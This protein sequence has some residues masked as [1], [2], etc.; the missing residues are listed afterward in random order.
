MFC[1][2]GYAF[3]EINGDDKLFNVFINL[4]KDVYIYSSAIHHLT[5]P[6]DNNLHGGPKKSWR[7]LM[8]HED[9]I[10][11]TLFVMK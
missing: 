3:K 9:D 11:C 10:Y 5:S 8:S 2:A 6:N 4:N 1:D 7:C